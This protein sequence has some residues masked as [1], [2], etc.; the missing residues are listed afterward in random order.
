[1]VCLSCGHGITESSG[2]RGMTREQGRECIHFPL[3]R[4]IGRRGNDIK[5]QT[6][7]YF[8]ASCVCAGG[9]ERDRRIIYIWKLPDGIENAVNRA[10]LEPLRCFLPME[11]PRS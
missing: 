8:L 9:W 11:A 6:K 2:S 7:E 1:M 4:V 3:E 10:C 5:K